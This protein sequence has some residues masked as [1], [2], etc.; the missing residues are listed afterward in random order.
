[1][2]QIVTIT[3]PL[4]GQP[5]QVDQL[6]HTAQEIDDGIA[7]AISGGAIDIALQNKADSSSVY[8]KEESIS[9]ATRT[10]L[11]LP[12]TATPDAALAEI[13]R[14]LSESGGA[15]MKVLWEN[16]S[17]NSEFASQTLTLDLSSFAFVIC[18]FKPV[19]NSIVEFCQVLRVGANLTRI[20]CTVNAEYGSSYMKYSERGLN[21]R[22]TYI[23]FGS[24]VSKN[25]NENSGTT[26]N[27][28][29]VP[30]LI[31]GIKGV[32]A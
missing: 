28:A 7:R 19:V 2:A 22:S 20:N 30:T 5:A 1:M 27:S 10:A 15:S 6:E 12:E 26:D 3:N 31:Y 9:A 16:A 8:T 23:S 11:S 21:V 17:P 32:S 18:A 25:Y 29:I 13:A 14:Q 4:T 24:A